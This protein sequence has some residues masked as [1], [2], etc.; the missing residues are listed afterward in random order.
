MHVEHL[1][2]GS[3]SRAEQA[4]RDEAHAASEVV[5]DAEGRPVLRSHGR[6]GWADYYRWYLDQGLSPGDAASAAASVV[7]GAA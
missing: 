6:R 4:M 5:C 2:T 1:D 7:E 3:V